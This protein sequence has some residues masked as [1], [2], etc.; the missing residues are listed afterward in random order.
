MIIIEPKKKKNIRFLKPMG[1]ITLLIFICFICPLPNN[2]A[3]N[4]VR[5]IIIYIGLMDVI[6][7]SKADIQDEND[8]FLEKAFTIINKDE[9]TYKLES[10]YSEIIDIVEHCKDNFLK[11]LKNVDDSIIV[12]NFNNDF[13]KNYHEN[14]SILKNYDVDIYHKASCLCTA[15][16]QAVGSFFIYSSKNSDIYTYN[17]NVNFAIYVAMYMT[18]FYK[19]PNAES[20]LPYFSYL[21]GIID[22]CSRGE[23]EIGSEK[24]LHCLAINLKKLHD[25]I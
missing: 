11:Y 12:E 1:C 15:L 13:I 6:K 4:V 5:L 20:I 23:P 19:N 2:I 17:Y 18:G 10:K 14:I 8:D 3:C 24:Q 9:E 7:N 21:N 22:A 25:L 16:L